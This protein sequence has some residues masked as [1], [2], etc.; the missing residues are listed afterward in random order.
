[1]GIEVIN[2]MK[3]KRYDGVYYKSALSEGGYNLTIFDD[4]KAKFKRTKLVRI[5]Q[6]KYIT[7][8]ASK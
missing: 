2:T 4:R 1:M 7:R 8:Q 3:N 5:T 6:V